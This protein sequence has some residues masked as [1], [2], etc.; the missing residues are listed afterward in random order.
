MNACTELR[1]IIHKNNQS[2]YIIFRELN[3]LERNA[4]EIFTHKSALLLFKS[5]LPNFFQHNSNYW[6]GD[7]EEKQ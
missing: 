5:A 2:S 4:L 6:N 1:H 7:K 3:T